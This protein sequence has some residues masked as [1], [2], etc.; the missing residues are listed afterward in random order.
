MWGLYTAR[1]LG[2]GGKNRNQLRSD[3]MPTQQR[4]IGTLGERRS[5][6]SDLAVPIRYAVEKIHVDATFV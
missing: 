6:Y 1:L 3:L 4:L 5:L 2:S